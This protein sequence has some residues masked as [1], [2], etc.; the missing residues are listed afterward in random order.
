[1]AYIDPSLNKFYKFDTFVEGLSEL[2]FIRIAL[3][4]AIAGIVLP[5]VGLDT[6][7]RCFFFGVPI[8]IVAKIFSFLLCAVEH[9]VT[10]VW[11]MS[12]FVSIEASIINGMLLPFS[13][14]GGQEGVINTAITIICAA[15]AGIAAL[16]LALAGIGFLIRIFIALFINR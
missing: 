7:S 5:V 15:L 14:I 1:M 3:F 6:V 16:A 2:P 9:P 13:V 12:L 4:N 11:V 8:A 10:K